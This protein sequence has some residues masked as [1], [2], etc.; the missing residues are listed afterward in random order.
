MQ[1][2]LAVLADYAS[3]DRSDKLTVAGIFRSVSAPNYPARHPS[4]VI[5]LQLEPEPEDENRTV[6]FAVRVLSPEGREVGGAMTGALDIGPV[7]TP[8]PTLNVLFNVHDLELRTP[9]PYLFEVVIDGR[10]TAELRL[11]ALRETGGR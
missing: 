5:A 10:K 3:V 6:D 9:G 11:D 8:P 1:T 4:L 2:L 7:P